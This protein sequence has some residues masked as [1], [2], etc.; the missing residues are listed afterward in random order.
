[1]KIAKFSGRHL[2]FLVTAFTMVGLLAAPLTTAFAANVTDRSVTLS[3]SS[4]G[5]TGVQYTVSFTTGTAAAGAAVIY[6]CN[7]SPLK[8]QA[9]TSPTG[10]T[11]ASATVAAPFTKVNSTANRIELTGTFAAS[12]AVEIELGGITNP[13]VASVAEPLY[14]RVVTYAAA[15]DATGTTATALGSNQVDDGGMAIAITPTIGISGDVLETLTFCVS[16]G[17]IADPEVSPI[18]DGCT[19]TLTAP[20]LK[21]GTDTGGIVSLQPG[22]VSEGKIFTQISTN[23]SKGAVVRL[24][25]NAVGC[26]GLLRAGSPAAC[27][28]APA[29]NTDIVAGD[30]KFGVKTAT[31][32]DGTGATGLYQPYGTLA[33]TPYYSNG[34]YAMRYVDATDGVTSAFGDRFLETAEAPAN[35]KSMALTF[36]VA[37]S[38][39]TPAGAYSADLSLIAVGTF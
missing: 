13:S 31:A 17:T 35:N 16:G 8:G 21:L 29:Q 6:F 36:G 38:N 18:G 20:T 32:T 22:V 15:G 2:G 23:A 12:T 7:N 4:V 27:D 11:A 37:A 28:I 26:G 25:S 39:N 30:A 9:C 14:A 19:G 1:M 33:S 34:A 24:K 5:A 3:S 10:F